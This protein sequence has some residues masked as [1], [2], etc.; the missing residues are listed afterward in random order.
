MRRLLRL[1]SGD[2]TSLPQVD[3]PP[4]TGQ[5]V[6]YIRYPGV[7]MSSV[8]AVSVAW[9][10]LSASRWSIRN[11][12]VSACCRVARPTP[13]LESNP[14]RSGPASCLG[15]PDGRAESSLPNRRGLK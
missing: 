12:R 8:V 13:V 5:L 9:A 3:L 6:G 4:A 11:F 15:S 2:V 14:H 7:S 10:F 1:E